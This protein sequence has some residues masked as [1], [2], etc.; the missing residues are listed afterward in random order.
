MSRLHTAVMKHYFQ[1][2]KL[3]LKD[4]LKRTYKPVRA[5]KDKKTKC[6]QCRIYLPLCFDGKKVKLRIAKKKEGDKN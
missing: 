4:A 6:Y 1:V 3:S 5:I 2:N